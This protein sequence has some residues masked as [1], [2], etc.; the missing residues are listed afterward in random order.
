MS[1]KSFELKFGR[2]HLRFTSKQ[3]LIFA[4]DKQGRRRD[5]HFS[6][7]FEPEK[8][9]LRPHFTTLGPSGKR[10]RFLGSVNL[11]R[12]TQ[13]LQAYQQDVDCLIMKSLKRVEPASLEENG[14][15]IVRP[16]LMQREWTARFMRT[17]STCAITEESLEGIGDVALDAA[18]PAGWLQHLTAETNLIGAFRVTEAG[19][20][21]E[22]GTLFYFP[23]G[24]NDGPGWYMA[25]NPLITR[26]QHA[27]LMLRHFP[28][29]FWEIV[30]AINDT[31]KLEGDREKLLQ[32][33]RSA[34]VSVALSPLTP[35]KIDGQY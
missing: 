9:R 6:Q 19:E 30:L 13:V 28:R 8:G 31:L 34:P 18:V 33:A 14:W 35:V 4:G 25:P 20:C 2:L 10:R 24:L 29:K 26:E 1:P 12:A 17:P 23:D 21:T 22:S 5:L 7:F 11:K 3:L 16:D 15:F 32:F 27:E